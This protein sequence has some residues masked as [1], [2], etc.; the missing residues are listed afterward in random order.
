M[1]LK[2]ICLHL[3][4]LHLIL[5]KILIIFFSTVTNVPLRTLKQ[6]TIYILRLHD[7]FT[8]L[9]RTVVNEDETA[10]PCKPRDMVAKLASS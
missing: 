8:V 7:S 5:R 1:L 2:E 6:S 4:S 3:I 9:P 10:N